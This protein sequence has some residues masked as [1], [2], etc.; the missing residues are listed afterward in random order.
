MLGTWAGLFVLVLASSLSLAQPKDKSAEEEPN[1]VAP[2]VPPEPV[3]RFGE[4]SFYDNPAEQKKRAEELYR[5]LM[6]TPPKAPAAGG[7]TEES[8]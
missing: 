1:S 4:G 3:R 6:E 2:A 7:P 5:E 8:N